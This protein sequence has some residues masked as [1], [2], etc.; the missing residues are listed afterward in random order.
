M[1]LEQ[2]FEEIFS[3]AIEEII[4]NAG[5]NSVKALRERLAKYTQPRLYKPKS[6]ALLK[7]SLLYIDENAGMLEGY[8][9]ANANT[10]SDEIYELLEDL[11]L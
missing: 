10:N 11:C 7:A 6:L 1:R 5:W 4:A 8:Y 2:V 3:K 9:D